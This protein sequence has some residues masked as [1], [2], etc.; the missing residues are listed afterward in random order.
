MFGAGTAA[1]VGA[2]IASRGL[3]AVVDAICAL[4]DRR[5]VVLETE[6]ISDDPVRRMDA[7]RDAAQGRLRF[8]DDSV[9]PPPDT[10]R[11]P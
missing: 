10:E 6:P 3:E 4:V 11:K 2:A 7:A 5:V 1:E 9:P 8:V